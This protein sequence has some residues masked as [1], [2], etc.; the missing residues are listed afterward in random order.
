MPLPV[1]NIASRELASLVEA[2]TA[3]TE[4]DLGETYFEAVF[5]KLDQTIRAGGCL[6]RTQVQGNYL[7][8]YP[9]QIQGRIDFERLKKEMRGWGLHSDD[10]AAVNSV[11]PAYSPAC[12]E[13]KTAIVLVCPG[14]DEWKQMRPAAK[15]T[16]K[17]L[18]AALRIWHQRARAHFP[19]PDRQDY[20]IVNIWP[21]V[22]FDGS[23]GRSEP[24]IGEIERR[25]RYIRRIRMLLEGSER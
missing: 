5:E 14:Q 17:N 24:S 18:E 19:S 6:D 15:S 9:N 20:R 11:S 22:E 10:P 13:Y 12:A 2:L 21:H 23:T 3:E 25:P 7:S 4:Y 8:H 1:D 16:G